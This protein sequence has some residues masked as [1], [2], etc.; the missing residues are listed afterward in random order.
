MGGREYGRVEGRG[1]AMQFHRL[2]KVL[3]GPQVLAFLVRLTSEVPRELLHQC[4][5]SY[6]QTPGYCEAANKAEKVKKTFNMLFKDIY[7]LILGRKCLWIQFYC[8]FVS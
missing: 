3:P 6:S 4:P 8:S 1:A 5:R 7:C 2:A